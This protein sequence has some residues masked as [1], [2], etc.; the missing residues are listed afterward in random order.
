MTLTHAYAGSNPA[1]SAKYKGLIQRQNSG[2]QNRIYWFDSISPCHIIHLLVYIE[3]FLHNYTIYN[4][5]QKSGALQLL[6]N[7]VYQLS[8]QSNW[9]LT[10][11]SQVRVLDEPP[12][13][14]C[15]LLRLFQHIRSALYMHKKSKQRMFLCIFQD[16]TPERLEDLWVGKPRFLQGGRFHINKY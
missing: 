14:V 1:S 3:V 4:D 10:N 2:L 16:D 9:L 6:T 13:M 15:L 5:L 7:L 8:R 11:G 12:V